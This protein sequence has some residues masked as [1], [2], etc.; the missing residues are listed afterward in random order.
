MY[1]NVSNAFLAKLN[2]DSRTFR[3]RITVNGNVTTDIKSYS[4]VSG[5]CGAD[6]FSIGTVFSSYV[7]V[8]IPVQDITLADQEFSL[9]TGLLLDNDNIE[10]IPMGYFTASPSDISKSR[11][12]II[13]RAADRI[14]SK[15]RKVYSPTIT[16]PASIQSII[17]DIESQAEITI[18]TSFNTSGIVNDQFPTMLCTDAL[19][20]IAGLLGGFCFADRFGRIRIEPFP[21]ESSLDVPGG[22]IFQLSVNESE[23]EM[24]R[25]SVTVRLGDE[26]AEDEDEE[27]LVYSVGSGNGIDLYNPYMTETL[28]NTMATRMQG[29]SYFPGNVEFLG[30]PRL[31]PTDAVTAE[32]Y[33]ESEFLIPCM[34]IIQTF[35]GGLK[36]TVTAP[37]MVSS[38]QAA[39]GPLSLQVGNLGQEVVIAKKAVEAAQ[40]SADAAANAA[41]SA[42]N[43]ANNAL[44]QLS[45]VEDVAGTLRWISEHG[46][47]VQ[48]IDT[49]VREGTVYFIYENGDYVPV[50]SPDPSKNPSE[51]GW[52]VLD[53]T[54]SQAK[55][56]M[57]HLA[58][59]SAG[60]WVLPVDQ[61]AEH[62][63]V[64]SD[65]NQ[66]ID[67]NDNT[68]VDFSADP[69]NASGYKV[70]LS[71]T[72]MSVYNDEGAVVANYGTT[73]TIGSALLRNVHIDS[74]AVYIRN[75]STVLAKYGSTTK[76]YEPDG[77][78]EAAEIGADGI[79]IKDGIIK[80]GN[81]IS[82][83]DTTH[84][85]TYI[86][87]DGNI[88]TSSI[89]ITGG[90]LSLGNKIS[91]S[92]TTNSGTYID[93]SGN[94]ATSNI[95]ATGGTIGAWSLSA[96]GL[97][98]TD[99]T[100]GKVAVV[101][102][103]G[104]AFAAGGTTH[105]SYSGCPF[106]VNIDGALFTSNITATGGT[107]GGWTISNNGLFYPN[108]AEAQAGV[109]KRSIWL[110]NGWNIVEVGYVDGPEG[111]V[112][113][114]T[115]SGENTI[116]IGNTVTWISLGLNGAWL[117]PYYDNECSLGHQSYRW[118]EVWAV[119]GSIRT[120]DRKDKDILGELDIETAKRLI[121]DS[122][123]VEYM[124]KDGDHRRTRMGFIAQDTA[125]ICKSM[126]KNLAL[127]T[128]SY[129]V[130]LSLEEKGNSPTKDYLGETI[131]DEQ[132][133]WGMAYDELIAPL[134]K[135]VQYQEKRITELE[136][137]LNG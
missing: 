121:L 104:W 42:N 31:D 58:V 84:T 1:Q 89:K 113:G 86:D 47:F 112:Y 29:Y 43:S 87:A 19:G 52:Y 126:N 26:N 71:G 4:L 82:A 108:E 103:S 100:T 105:E 3:S 48:T 85:G 63:L 57:A 49:T 83:S 59:T 64:D 7:D 81:K 36:T 44:T 10:Y 94:I 38:D 6:V 97:R 41:A 102:P 70:L 76:F 128:A 119:N 66:M 107:V 95:L 96:T 54:E 111:K 2:H 123:P 136:V 93:S 12:Q 75:G 9:E 133:V 53:V 30:D 110:G 69:Q 132:L 117:R 65:D 60:L 116:T 90:Y 51:E 129:K 137:R 24:S 45:I 56:I 8:A 101:K 22:R 39:Q 73:T 74:E 88:A 125:E 25:I 124:W 13:I 15:C 50:T 80:L 61:M 109:T 27:P 37:G 21:E 68:L 11:D 28:F 20:Y 115:N 134:V 55:Y 67:S 106:R 122:N 33:E 17:N 62:P 35:D 91:A 23:Y 98:A 14:N 120:S 46:S 118:T 34:Q 77:T 18:R 131:D 32:D 99:S 16:F 114:L 92:D 79:T 5:S 135:M 127:V 130:D 72:G 40:D 78:T